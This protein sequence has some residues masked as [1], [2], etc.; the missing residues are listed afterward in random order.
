MAGYTI[1]RST[2]RK[3]VKRVLPGELCIISQNENNYKVVFKRYY[4][5]YL[6]FERLNKNYDLSKF[7]IKLDKVLNKSIQ[8]LINQANGRVIVLSLSSSFDSRLILG[9][10]LELK[11]KNILCYSYGSKNNF[12]ALEAEKNSKTSKYTLVFYPDLSAKEKQKYFAN[13][14]L[15]DYFVWSSGLST[16]ASMTE[17]IYLEKLLKIKPELKDAIFTNGQ[18]GD[19]I[20]GGHLLK[21]NDRYSKNDFLNSFFKKHFSLLNVKKI[22]LNKKKLIFNN[23]IS[24]SRLEKINFSNYYSIWALMEWQEDNLSM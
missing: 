16:T 19:F 22:S 2:I 6:D 17:F 10:L 13:G 18:S 21:I 9:K 14:K 8:R 3:S 4:T 20:T 1:G 23:W 24:S 12:E 11:Y 5:Y 7:Y 15:N